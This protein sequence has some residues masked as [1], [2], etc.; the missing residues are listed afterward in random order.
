[1]VQLGFTIK[2]Y[3]VRPP[4]VETNITGERTNAHPADCDLADEETQSEGGELFKSNNEVIILFAAEW[5][6]RLKNNY[7]TKAYGFA[8]DGKVNILMKYLFSTFAFG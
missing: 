2:H 8:P 1:M 5:S 6:N 4:H 7:G 3:S